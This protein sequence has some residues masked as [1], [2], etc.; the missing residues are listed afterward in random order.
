MDAPSVSK[1][2]VVVMENKSGEERSI[3]LFSP[4]CDIPED[5]IVSIRNDSGDFNY[6]EFVKELHKSKKSMMAS[7]IR[8]HSDDFPDFMNKIVVRKDKE[9]VSSSYD[10]LPILYMSS[11]HPLSQIAH[12]QPYQMWIESGFSMNVILQPN[13][14]IS[15][16]FLIGAE[17]ENN[18]GVKMEYLAKRGAKDIYGACIPVMIEN[19]SDEIVDVKL[20]DVG[21]YSK[22]S[23]SPVK[24]TTVAGWSYDEIMKAL[25]D[26][27]GADNFKE[28]TSKFNSLKIWS[29]NTKQFGSRH[30]RGGEMFFKELDRK[31]ENEKNIFKET[32]VLPVWYF[33]P[34][35]YHPNFLDIDGVM[36]YAWDKDCFIKIEVMPKT[37]ALYI[38]Y[39]LISDR[40]R[41]IAEFELAN[42]NVLSRLNLKVTR[43]EEASS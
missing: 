2:I 41:D 26:D 5:V 29:D 6:H 35:Q 16:S 30:H 15:Y 33:S 38:F 4:D 17:M 27:S 14:T 9:S 42:K 23:D 43:M 34:H 10:L 22:K 36:K 39:E 37:K 25:K 19:T 31:D 32:F 3:N 20:F 7:G 13:K 11:F 24:I 1:I 8:I 21:G 40:E 18:H 28:L 12:I